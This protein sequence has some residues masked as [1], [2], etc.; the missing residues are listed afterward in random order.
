M[1]YVLLAWLTLWPGAATAAPDAPKIQ[2]FTTS[3]EEFVLDGKPHLIRSGELHYPRVPAEYWRDRMKKMRSMGLNTLSTYVFWNLHEPKP[4]QFDFS[5][6]LDLARFIKTA[7]EEGLNVLLRPGPYICGEWEFGGIPSWLLK[8][9][10]LQVRTSDPRFLSAVDR[11]L[12]KVGEQVSRLMVQRGGPILMVQVENEYGSFGTD[13]AY[14]NA[15]KKSVRNAGFDGPLFTSDSVWGHAEAQKELGFGTFPEDL[16][17]VNFNQNLTPATQ[18]AE[19]TKFRPESP[20]MCAEYWVGWFDQVGGAHAVKSSSEGITGLSW[21]MQHNVSFNIYMFHG[22]TNFGFM[23]GADWN[24]GFYLPDTTNYDYDAPLDEAGRPTEKFFAYRDTIAKNLAEKEDFPALPQEIPMISI[25][26][27]ALSE[28]APLV[29][30]LPQ[31]ISSER[32]KSMED[33]DQAYGFI[34]YQHMITAPY[35]GLLEIKDVHDYALVSQGGKLLGTLDRRLKQSALDLRLEA[36]KPLEILVENMGR[37]NFSPQMQGER[38]GITES[39]ISEKGELLGWTIYSLPLDN[40]ST[41]RFGKQVATGPAFYRGHFDLAEVGDTYLDTRGWGKGVVFINGHN[42]GRYWHIG[43]QHALYC[44][45]SW[46]KKGKN[47]VIVFD[48]DSMGQRTMQGLT[49][50]V[51]D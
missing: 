49:H 3:D 42:L 41:L 12:K 47:E 27:F 40:L 14:M 17:T 16:V 25:P 38:K 44:P 45:A 34:L 18:L 28:N 5:G 37:L 35:R 51:Y 36:G 50:P 10:G 8:M 23:N 19:L 1:K 9:P 39:V 48:L 31:P 15:I 43:P 7:A 6:Q 26:D 30:L 22:G 46:L 4:G 32:P 33:V 13:R 24:H 2:T 11:Y 21:M 29:Q 20:A